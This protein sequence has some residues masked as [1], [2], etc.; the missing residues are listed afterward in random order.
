M[1]DNKN[2]MNH[3]LIEHAPLFK[4]AV[5]KLKSAGHFHDGLNIDE[6]DL[7][8]H[9]MVG[10]MKAASTWESGTSDKKWHNYALK[11]IMDHMH[12]H[13]KNQD[14]V[15]RRLRAEAKKQAASPKPETPQ[16]D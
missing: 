12:Q 8:E 7:K 6:N 9:G 1:A 10:L 2:L 4:R 15:H 11:G 3:F 14:P 13:I 16:E 5:N